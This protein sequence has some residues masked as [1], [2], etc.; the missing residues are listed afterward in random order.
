[1]Y[2]HAFLA[3]IGIAMLWV[4]GMFIVPLIICI[5]AMFLFDIEQD[6]T[7]IVFW[8]SWVLYMIL[9]AIVLIII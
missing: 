8:V 6:T 2:L 1:M 9:S 5:A 7:Q 3:G 4:M